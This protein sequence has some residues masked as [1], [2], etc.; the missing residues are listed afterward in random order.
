MKHSRIFLIFL[1]VLSAIVC[2]GQ[3][4]LSG[5]AS[6]SEYKYA[7]Y[8]TWLSLSNFGKAETNTIHYEIQARYS[9]TERDA[10][11]IKL[12][13]W[14]L[15]APL[16]IPIWDDKFL[17][18]DY[19][20]QGRLRETGAG[21]VYQRRLWKR[22]FATLEILAFKTTYLDETDTNIGNGFKLYNSYHLG[23]HVPLFKKGRF[24]IEPQLH[25]NHWPVN[26]NVPESF[27][28]EERKW[29]NFFLIEPNIYFGVKF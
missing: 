15:F 28:L 3:I 23:Y 24:F 18:E 13:T 19:F 22:L 17:D 12:A 6:N 29:G 10:V 27:E 26:T 8:T 20:Y 25:V 4:S 7:I 2:S 11:G 1:I 21:I 16:G 5:E 9:V 14:K